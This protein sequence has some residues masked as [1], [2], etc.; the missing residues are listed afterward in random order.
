M[1]CRCGKECE[2]KTQEDMIEF[3]TITYRTMSGTFPYFPTTETKKVGDIMKPFI[4]E[5]KERKEK[6]TV[7]ALVDTDCL[8]AIKPNK[9]FVYIYRSHR[10]ESYN[11]LVKGLEHKYVFV[12][13]L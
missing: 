2:M 4:I 1:E 13:F 6:L 8:L 7:I 12:K 3:R 11:R 5:H 9:E 10:E